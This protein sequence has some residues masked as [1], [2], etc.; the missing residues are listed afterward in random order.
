MIKYRLYKIVLVS[1]DKFP[2]I[3]NFFFL[4]N[5]KEIWMWDSDVESSLAIK[6]IF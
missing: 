6:D 3:A 2:D 4:A 5:N 1:L